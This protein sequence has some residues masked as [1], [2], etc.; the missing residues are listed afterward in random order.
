MAIHFLKRSTD[1]FKP[2]RSDGRTSAGGGLRS[3][4]E[5]I[6][7]HHLAGCHD[8]QG[9]RSLRRD[10]TPHFHL[11]VHHHHHHHLSSDGITRMWSRIKD[12]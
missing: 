2:P 7:I 6:F 8:Y 12:Q 4:C 3:F 5:S 10:D 11:V 1:E 9:V